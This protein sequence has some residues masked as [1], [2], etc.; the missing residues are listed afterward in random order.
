MTLADYT[1]G[2]TL[3]GTLPDGTGYSVPTFVPDQTKVD[4]GGGGFLLTN[5]NA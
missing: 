5:W 4:E 3:T 2:P 1:P